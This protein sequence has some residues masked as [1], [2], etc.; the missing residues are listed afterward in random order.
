MTGSWMSSVVC[1]V[2]LRDDSD[3]GG[4]TNV[5]PLPAMQIKLIVELCLPLTALV[6]ILL[7]AVT[8]PPEACHRLFWSLRFEFFP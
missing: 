5:L 6:S 2:N 3:L 7:K 4:D 8:V 1:S